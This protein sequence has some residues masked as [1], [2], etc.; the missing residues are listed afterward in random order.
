MLIAHVLF[1]DLINRRDLESHLSFG[2]GRSSCAAP[3]SVGLQKD[4]D[5]TSAILKKFFDP[6][7]HQAWS[8]RVRRPEVFECSSGRRGEETLQDMLLVGGY[9]LG[10]PV[11][12][13]DA[14]TMWEDCHS[15]Q[16]NVKQSN[17]TEIG[18]AHV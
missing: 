9:S 1:E 3:I 5:T 4:V 10:S 13:P 16:C 8:H 11:L 7:G 12:G 6:V 14:R 18:R 17:T 2:S 15:E